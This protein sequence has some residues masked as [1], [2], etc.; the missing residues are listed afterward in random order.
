MQ[1][2]PSFRLAF[3]RAAQP[4]AD[5]FR[6]RAAD[7][8]R[9][10]ARPAEIHGKPGDLLSFPSEY[11]YASPTLLA[12]GDE[13]G[14]THK[15]WVTVGKY[16]SI[17][18]G[19]RIL[20]GGE[21]HPEWVS[22]YPFRIVKGLPGRYEDGQ[23]S[24]RGPIT[25]GNDVW[26]GYD[27]VILS[28]VTIGDGAVIATGTFL[29]KDVEAYAKVGGNPGETFGYRFDDETIA[30]LLRIRWWDWP[31]DKVLAHV[32]QL[33]GPDLAGFVAEHDPGDRAS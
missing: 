5:Q 12:F 19:T 8:V 1:R 31:D 30:S 32:S 28:G 26:V 24:S 14:V 10:L 21:H 33:N 15:P 13:P 27:V 3:H 4:Y 16:S 2:V 7:M 11:S 6:R 20:V 29:R 17:C 9:R 18:G 25:I 22:T 23:P